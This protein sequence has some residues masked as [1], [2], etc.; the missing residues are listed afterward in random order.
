MDSTD[1]KKQEFKE[2]ADK[3]WE[4]LRS[5]CY[6]DESWKASFTKEG[7]DVSKYAF[8]WLQTHRFNCISHV[9]NHLIYQT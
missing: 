6:E 3:A 5:W 2:L 1:S 4:Q 9:T 7:V 8:S